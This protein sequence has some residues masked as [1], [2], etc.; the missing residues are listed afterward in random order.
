VR[1]WVKQGNVGVGHGAGVTI[2]EAE[3]M[4]ETE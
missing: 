3:R 2:S 4:R 1:I